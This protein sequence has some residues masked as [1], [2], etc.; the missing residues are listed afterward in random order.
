MSFPITSVAAPISIQPIALPASIQPAAQAHG[1]FQSV[2][3]DA[4][5]QLQHLQHTANSNI[6]NLLSGEN[7]EI[8]HVALATQ[9]SELA[10][11]LFMQVRN[12][13]VQAY[14]EVM[15]MQM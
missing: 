8:H 12:K 9:Q 11:E 13:V 1:S 10:F 3:S 14:Q 4:I 7:V 5:G 6:D 15:R 2:F